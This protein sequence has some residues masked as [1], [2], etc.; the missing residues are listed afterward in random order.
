MSYDSLMK[1]LGIDKESDLGVAFFKLDKTYEE[2][3]NLKKEIRA[4]VKTHTE[5]VKRLEQR[6]EDVEIM[7]LAM[8]HKFNQDTRFSK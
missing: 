5:L 4:V 6:L 1:K 3:E 7:E 2:I 8:M